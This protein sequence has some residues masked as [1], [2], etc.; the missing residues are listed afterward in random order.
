MDWLD[1]TQDR[2]GWHAFL[3]A[4]MNLRFQYNAGNFLTR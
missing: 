1:L 4:I 2:D 3:N